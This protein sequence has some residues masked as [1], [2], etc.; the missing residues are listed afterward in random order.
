MFMIAAVLWVLIV[1]FVPRVWGSRDE[2]GDGGNSTGGVGRVI[3]VIGG[4]PFDARVAASTS[5]QAAAL[6]GVGQGRTT[7]EAG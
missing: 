5:Q 2:G 7:V 3:R 6:A 4:D 1:A